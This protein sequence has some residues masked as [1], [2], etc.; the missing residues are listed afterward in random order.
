MKTKKVDQFKHWS[1]DIP[2][3]GKTR[4][5]KQQRPRNKCLQQSVLPAEQ[6][7]LQDKEEFGQQR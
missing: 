1:L 7:Q 6:I 2:V 3:F 4:N 5:D